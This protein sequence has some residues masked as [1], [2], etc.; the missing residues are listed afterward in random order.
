MNKLTT[1]I[2]LALTIIFF[3]AFSCEEDVGLPK[4]IEKWKLIA[5][6]A[7]PGD[8]SGTF[9]PVESDRIIEFIVDE[10]IVRSNGSFCG[11]GTSAD[12]DATAIY[13]ANEK[14]ILIEDCGGTGFKILYDFDEEF[15]YLR[16]PCIEPCVQK[17]ERLE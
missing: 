15:L 2:F 17:Y 6:L 4:S 16:F 8:G 11:M 7:H 10:D 9:Q 13:N 5:Q 3:T 12:E 1:F 14:Y